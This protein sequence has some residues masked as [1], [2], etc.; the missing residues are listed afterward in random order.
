[1]NRQ[2]NFSMN[3]SFGWIGGYHLPGFCTSFAV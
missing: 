3:V 2:D 1:M